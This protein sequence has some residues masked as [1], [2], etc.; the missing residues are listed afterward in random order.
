VTFL[1]E[2][3]DSILVKQGYFESREK[4]KA[5]VM[6]GLVYVDKQLCNKAGTQVKE[7]A[8]IDI[9]QALCPYVGRGG[10]KLEKALNLFGIDPTGYAA[11]DMGA[12]TGGFTDCLLQKGASKVY[13]I[14][15]GYGQLHY[16]LRNDERVVNIERTNIRYLDTNKILDT[17]DLISIDV[18]F[19]SVD[20][21]FPVAAKLLREDGIVICLIKPQFEAGRSQVGKHGI[22]K[23]RSVHTEV[24]R[25][26]MKYGEDRGL[27]TEALTWS[28]LT[29]AKGNIEYLIL[30]RKTADAGIGTI[31][32]RTTVDS[33]F[34]YFFEKPDI[35]KEI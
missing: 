19:I 20:L 11:V 25:K 26:V 15:V 17:I 28:P 3:L 29:G 22:V 24:I 31:D 18:S 30:L 35:E 13:A 12:S 4:A 27:K 9:K 10:L 32:E 23:E 7:T 1:K 21:I 33:A 34:A 8:L 6:A 16:K 14:D 2:R 5:A